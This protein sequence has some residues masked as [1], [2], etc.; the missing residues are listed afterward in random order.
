MWG[1]EVRQ[2]GKAA[3]HV[4]TLGPWSFTLP[5]YSAESRKIASE[6]S[7]LRREGAG[8]YIIHHWSSV[9]DMGAMELLEG[10]GGRTVLP[11]EKTLGDQRTKQATP[12]HLHRLLFRIT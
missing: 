6:S 3:G 2:E 1:Q 10:G 8:I 4:T 9:K 7:H 11:T 5:R 12:Y